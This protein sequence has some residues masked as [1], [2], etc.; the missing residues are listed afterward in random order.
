M[1]FQALKSATAAAAYDRENVSVL[2][3]LARDARECFQQQAAALL[4]LGERLEGAFGSAARLLYRVEGH[5]VVTGI[6]KSGLI[7]QK[8]AATLAST[9]TPSFFLHAAEAFHGDLGMVTEHDAVMLIS[10]SGETEEVVRLM[11]HLQRRGVPM[12][13][14]VGNPSSSLARGVD[15]SLDVSV[16][17]EVCPNNLAPT[18]STL[19]TL[20]MGD[21]LAVTLIKMRGF[22]AEDFAQL[23]PGGSLG[24]RLLSR[25]RD[26]MCQAALPTVAA[27]ATAR[28]CVLPLAGSKLNMVLVMDGDRLLGIVTHEELRSAIEAPDACLD[29]PAREI[30]N[31]QPPLVDA[32]ACVGEAERIMRREGVT[33]V[34]AVDG[35]GRVCGVVE[36]DVG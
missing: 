5:V 13:G 18:S 21:A 11:P 7:G 29:L 15:V 2:D 36:S 27:D 26:V 19:A 3:P 12:V 33:A 30:M 14:L 31:P 35:S 17:R 25:V 6:G 34:V 8:I 10:Y 9:G 23:H 28:D 4:A 22:H 20:A 32:N 24:R 16:D 1:R